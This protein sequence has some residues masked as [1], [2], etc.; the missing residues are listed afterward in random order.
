MPI[1]KSYTRYKNSLFLKADPGFDIENL[2]QKLETEEIKT[3]FRDINTGD[4]DS[5]FDEKFYT[6][7]FKIELANVWT[8]GF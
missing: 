4:N 8:D 6:Y 5:Y 7:R 1:I 3:K 2:R